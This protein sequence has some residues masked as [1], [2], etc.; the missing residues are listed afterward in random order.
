MFTRQTPISVFPYTEN[1]SPC[2]CV[3]PYVYGCWICVYVDAQAIQPVSHPYLFH[4]G[5]YFVTPRLSPHSCRHDEK[6]ISPATTYSKKNAVLSMWKNSSGA[7]GPSL[8]WCACHIHQLVWFVQE[9]SWKHLSS[10]ASMS[11]VTGITSA[12]IGSRRFSIMKLWRVRALERWQPNCA[13]L[14]PIITFGE[15]VRLGHHGKVVMCPVTC[16]SNMKVA[17]LLF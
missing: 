6:E 17:L 7:L 15:Q 11:E 4:S 2:A 10:N 5:K 3:N 12:V 8:V 16:C 14:Q 13:E 1:K 9:F